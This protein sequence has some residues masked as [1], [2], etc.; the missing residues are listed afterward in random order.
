[1]APGK[2]KC[3]EGANND[4]G[5]G[6]NKDHHRL[7]RTPKHKTKYGSRKEK[8]HAPNA[9]DNSRM[10]QA[11]VCASRFGDF[12][13]TFIKNHLGKAPYA[14]PLLRILRQ[15]VQVAI[16][17]HVDELKKMRHPNNPVEILTDP[18]NRE[19]GFRPNYPVA[20]AIIHNPADN[21]PTNREMC[22]NAIITINNSR[23]VQI[24]GYGNSPGT[25]NPTNLICFAGD[26]TP[27]G[28][29]E[30]AP[31]ASDFLTIGDLMDIIGELHTTEEGNRPSDAELVADDDILAHY[32]SPNLHTHVRALYTPNP[33]GAGFA[34]GFNL[35][36]M[37]F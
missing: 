23:R 21:T 33:A 11:T 17:A 37:D 9:E 28:G 27:S 1:M 6:P 4:N 31:Y 32:F 30:E 29:L 12:V 13:L 10:M 18:P 36:S 25:R 16:Q 35:P 15:E 7:V 2:K 14:Q 26:L 24:D 8:P 5:G 22:A 19:G 20:I 34:P 3:A